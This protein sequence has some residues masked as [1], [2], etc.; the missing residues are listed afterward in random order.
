MTATTI[1]RDEW[2]DVVFEAIHA[3]RAALADPATSV[4][5]AVELLKLEVARIRHGRAVAGTDVPLGSLVVGR[6]SGRGTN[7]TTTGRWSAS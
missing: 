1:R 7:W 6:P 2:A 5:A 4:T 3:L